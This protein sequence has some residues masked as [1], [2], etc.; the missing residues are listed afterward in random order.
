[1][2]HS[3]TLC[4]C[5]FLCSTLCLVSGV[6]NQ[7]IDLTLQRGGEFVVIALFHLS[8]QVAISCSTSSAGLRSV[9]LIFPVPAT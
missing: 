5:G 6:L 2:A 3:I 7:F 1:M 9:T 8:F 4:Y